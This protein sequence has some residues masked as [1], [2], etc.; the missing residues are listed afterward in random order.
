MLRIEDALRIILERTPLVAEEEAP[1]SQSAGRVLRREAISDIDL[2]PFDRSR[3][4]GYALRAADVQS[5]AAGRPARLRAIGEAAA[6]GSFASRVETG[7]A[8]RIMTGAPVPE[9]ADAVQKIEVINVLGD[10]WI[11]VQEPVQPGQFIAPRGIEARA[12]KVMIEAG[13]RITPPVASVLA[14]FGY[15]RVTVSRRPRLIVLSTG[16]ELVEVGEKPGPSQIRNSN[17]FSL[18]G[19][20]DAAGAEVLGASQVRDDLPQTRQAISQA[21]S[22]A[23]VLI[24]S[25]GVSMG[26][27]DLVKPALLD[28]GAEIYVEKVAMHPGK[29]TV[30]AKLGDKVIFGLPGNPVSVAISFHLFVR[31]ALLKMQGATEIQ[32]PQIRAYAS[33]PVKGA[34]PRRSH[35][36]ARLVFRDGR[37]EAEPLKWSGSSDLVAFM[38]AEALIVVPED[39]GSIDQGELIEVILLR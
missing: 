7:E 24:L 32:P 37:I 22:Q 4:D 27:Y 28:L 31:P 38:R 34:P 20:A 17:T 12:G 30:F 25:G 35:Q 6:G 2:P 18:A 10:G 3:M 8:V 29:P 16:T 14:S 26:D 13:E 9:G 5:A 1:L 19:Y 21:L 33:Q 11:E 39:R 23:E 36:P 15:A